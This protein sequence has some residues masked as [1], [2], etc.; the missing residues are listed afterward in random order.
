MLP[1]VFRFQRLVKDVTTAFHLHWVPFSLFSISL[2]V[3]SFFLSFSLSFVLRPFFSRASGRRRHVP[4]RHSFHLSSR[5][6]CVFFFSNIYFVLSFYSFFLSFF[7]FR[8]PFIDNWPT[9]LRWFF[10]WFLWPP[11]EFGVC[12]SVCGRGLSIDFVWRAVIG[13]RDGAGRPINCVLPRTRCCGQS[14]EVCSR[15]WLSPHHHVRHCSF[16]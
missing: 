6:D 4:G 16:S 10:F 13:R 11:T 9:S 14:N 15:R 5:C 12:V 1:L 8:L 2:S 7:L 3:F